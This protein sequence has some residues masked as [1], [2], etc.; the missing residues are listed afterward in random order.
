[1]QRG[2]LINGNYKP[3]RVIGY[4]CDAPAQTLVK[5]IK[6]HTGYFSCEKFV[7]EVNL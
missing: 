3:F 1:M 7:V 5:Q 4:I 2:I 6:G